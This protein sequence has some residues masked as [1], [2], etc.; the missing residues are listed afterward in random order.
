M[1]TGVKDIRKLERRARGM[2][3]TKQIP[4]SKM[5]IVRSLLN[6]SSLLPEEKYSAVIDLIK[7]CPDKPQILQSKSNEKV[8]TQ[9]SSNNP[10]NS[11]PKTLLTRTSLFGPTSESVFI[12]K[13]YTKYKFTGFFKKKYLIRTNSIFKFAFRKRL[14]PSKNL[15]K[16]LNIFINFQKNILVRL[17][18]IMNLILE[19]DNYDNPEIYNYLKK[20]QEMLNETPIVSMSL[21]QASGLDFRGYE[22]ELKHFT[23]KFIAFMDLDTETKEQIISTIESKLRSMDDLKKE[24]TETTSGT[25][26][27]KRNLKREKYVYDYMMSVR[28][29]LPQYKISAGAAEKILQQKY[30]INNL[31]DFILILNEALVFRHITGFEELRKYYEIQPV[32]VSSLKWNCPEEELKRVGK[33][34]E[35]RVKR[36]RERLKKEVEPLDEIVK[37]ITMKVDGMDLITKAF[38]NQ[39]RIINKRRQEYGNLFEENFFLFLDESINYFYN[40]LIPYIDGTPL[41]LIDSTGRTYTSPIFSSGYFEMKKSLL[42]DILSDLITYRTNNPSSI[43]TRDEAK[44]ICSGQLSTMDDVKNFLYRIGNLFYEIGYE[45]HRLERIHQNFLKQDQTSKKPTAYKPLSKDENAPA[46]KEDTARP[47]PFY[48][49]RIQKNETNPDW[50]KLYSGRTVL[51]DSVKDSIIKFI[52][53]FSY[54]TSY[55]CYNETLYNELAHRKDIKHKIKELIGRR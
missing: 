44:K 39:W 48:D 43:V 52:I 4:A 29:F 15:F 51:G 17:P 47:F 12:N 38:D 34:E 20:L 26:A 25:D 24:N 30:A 5:D 42:N 14:V 55:E 27:E 9:K 21:N 19:D 13:I 50:L 45:L 53:S 37:Y 32:T 40:I 46:D 10:K 11:K 54:Q 41:N 8:N 36:Y 22:R 49:C 28:S 16:L 2:L 33:D 18:E 35:S 1:D 3:T 7:T 23:V 31:A 6:N